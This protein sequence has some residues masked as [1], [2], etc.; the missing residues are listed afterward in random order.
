MKVQK[1]EMK[2]A[3]ANQGDV[4]FAIKKITMCEPAQIKRNLP[5]DQNCQK[6]ED[7]LALLYNE[8]RIMN[9]HSV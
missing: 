5:M 6:Y 8:N 4:K 3:K 9:M 7:E 1:V 2:V